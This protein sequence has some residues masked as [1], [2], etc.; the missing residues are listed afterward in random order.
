MAEYTLIIKDLLSGNKEV[1][2]QSINLSP[3]YDMY[4][5]D[6]FASKIGIANRETL[7]K[8]IEQ[9]LFRDEINSQNLDSIISKWITDIKMGRKRTVI[10]LDLPLSNQASSANIQTESILS[11]IPKKDKLIRTSPPVVNPTVVNPPNSNISNPNI[12]KLVDVKKI[13]QRTSPEP[14]DTQITRADDNRADI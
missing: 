14:E 4:P 12:P 6:Y 1:T 8:N 2:V 13:D 7:R 10:P 5:E 11:L 9:K 3:I